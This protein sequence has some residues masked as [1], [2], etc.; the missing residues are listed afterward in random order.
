MI[1]DYVTKEE[2]PSAGKDYS[3][4]KIE[5]RGLTNDEIV[6]LAMTDLSNLEN[7]LENLIKNNKIITNV[8]YENIYDMD[9]YVIYYK[10]RQ[11]SFTTADYK[12]KYDCP[13]CNT[14]NDFILNTNDDLS[15][16]FW[17]GNLIEIPIK[18]EDKEVFKLKIRPSKLSDRN[19]KN[20]IQGFD[21]VK[22]EVAELA[23]SVTNIPLQEMY[24]IILG[25]ESEIFGKLTGLELAH[26]I[27]SYSKLNSYGFKPYVNTKIC[28]HCGGDVNNIPFQMGFINFI[29]TL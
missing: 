23:A 10:I 13:N 24:E 28:S 12:I 25:E 19:A 11:I 29:P 14:T 3:V 5:I 18:R 17:D 4:D 6:L 21:N 2:L 26:L 15:I 8:K 20:I 22:Q 1:L 9:K 27:S 16:D 7:V